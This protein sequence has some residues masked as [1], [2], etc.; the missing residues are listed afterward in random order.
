MEP[1]TLWSLYRETGDP[2]ARDTLLRESVDLVHWI[3]RR[4]GKQLGGRYE[5]AELVSAGTLGLLSA[6]DTFDPSRGLAFGT[7]AAPRIRGAILDDLRAQDRLTRKAR[8]HCW[9]PS[10][11][12]RAVERRDSDAAE[13]FFRRLLG[14]ADTAP[15]RIVTDKLASYAVAKQRISA[16]DSTKHLHVRAAARLNNRVE[17]SHQPTRLRERRM[18]RFK[19]PAHA[20]RFLS[21]F[22]RTCTLF[23]PR[24]H[25]LTASNYRTTMRGRFQTWREVTHAVA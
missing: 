13:R 21:V 15:E 6:V 11:A 16:L 22:S 23:R 14:Q 3:A 1:S 20:Q 5:H 12:E 18:Q 7:F 2:T 17:Q 9:T 10:D 25:R 24:R 19:S 4:M 8:E